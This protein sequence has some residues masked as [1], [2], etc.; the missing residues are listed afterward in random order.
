MP[1]NIPNIDPPLIDVK[2][3]NPVTYLK[4][5]WAKIIDNE[6]VDLSFHIRP[7]TAILISLA[8]ASVGFGFGRFVLPFELP[9]FKYI[10]NTLSSP[11]PT[12]TEEPVWRE[13]AFTG[14]LQY[15]DTINKYYLVTTSSEAITLDVPE[16]IDLNELVGKRILAAGPYNKSERVLKV[17][18][19]KNMEVLPKTPVAVPTNSPTPSPTLEPT[20]TPTSEPYS[21]NP[22][23]DSGQ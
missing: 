6:G 12:P 23:L 20:I 17:T 3:T 11:I 14:N 18:D 15:S 19:A 1:D 2:V 10:D 21:S 8:I 16:N 13:T 5:W 4:K 7:L 22:S 9:F